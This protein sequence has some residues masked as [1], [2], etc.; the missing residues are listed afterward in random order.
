MPQSIPYQISRTMLSELKAS[1]SLDHMIWRDNPAT[2][3][4]VAVDGKRVAWLEDGDDS[5]TGEKSAQQDRRVFS[6]RVGV[7]AVPSRAQM[8]QA[9]SAEELSGVL[10]AQVDAD[11]VAVKAVVLRAW[12]VWADANTKGRLPLISA[13]ASM[14]E[15][16]RSS[17]IDG[18]SAE[19]AAIMTTFEFQ[20]QEAARSV[21]G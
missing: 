16:L 2:P 11:M 20:Y 6:L 8:E 19:S 18:I 5:P 1:A 13:V 10:R 21:R 12:Q 4:D 3:A 7:A 14:R 17:R 15:G 9:A